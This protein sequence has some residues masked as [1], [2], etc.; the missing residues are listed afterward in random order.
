MSDAFIDA[1]RDAVGAAQVLVEGDLSAY[2]LDWRKRWRGRARAVVRP[3]S[4]QEVAAVVRA[5]AQHRVAVV[6]QGGNTGL[7]GAGVPDASGTQVLL[8][9][10]R[11]KTIR[12]IDRANLTLTAADTNG[13]L[14]GSVAA[15]RPGR[16]LSRQSHL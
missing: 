10:A 12:A 11:M 9:L 15:M 3:G 4:T 14:D 7:V 1:L 16:M 13:G 5:C 8:S 2:E 6:A